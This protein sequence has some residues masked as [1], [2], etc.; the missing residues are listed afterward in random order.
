METMVRLRRL[1]PTG[2][3]I[4]AVALLCARLASGQNEHV[5]GTEERLSSAIVGD[6]YHLPPDTKALPDFAT[7]APVGR[8]YASTLNIPARSWTAGFPGVTERF[9]WFGIDY[10]GRFRVDRPGRHRFRLH[11]DDGSRLF[12]DGA[13]VIDNDGLH[14]P[15]SRTGTVDLDGSEHTLLLQYFQGP[16]HQ[17]ALQLFVA[18]DGEP[19][20]PFPGKAVTLEPHVELRWLRL[21]GGEPFAATEAA[22]GDLVMLEAI[23]SIPSDDEVERATVSISDGES[24]E[25]ELRRTE[26][27][28]VYR[29]ERFRLGG[30]P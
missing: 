12:I 28:T 14:P 6:V 25:I 26:D 23:F 9:E 16:A 19:E 20:A 7:L 15:E 17:I 11:S 29:S 3:A 21:D 10:Q 4:V 27:P 13:L 2:I 8:I 30:E 18:R 22:P 1:A 5:F 24:L